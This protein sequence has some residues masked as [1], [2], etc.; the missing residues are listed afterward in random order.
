MY[1]N[2]MYDDKAG[3]VQLTAVPFTAIKFMPRHC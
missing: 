3:D 1:Y 2:V